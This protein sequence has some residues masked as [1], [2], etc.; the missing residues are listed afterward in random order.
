MTSLQRMYREHLYR[1]CTDVQRT[2]FIHYGED[3][4]TSLAFELSSE[5]KVRAIIPSK[6]FIVIPPLWNFFSPVLF[7]IIFLNII[8]SGNWKS[9][10]SYLYR[11]T[12]LLEGI[13][14]ILNVFWTDCIWSY[15]IQFWRD[16]RHL[17][18]YIWHSTTW[19]HWVHDCWR[20]SDYHKNGYVM[21]IVNESS[22]GICSSLIILVH[23]NN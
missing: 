16:Q 6:A 19:K 7:C 17:Q 8:V 21:L 11:N 14:M 4:C 23:S 22:T 1:G 15:G 2:F 3:E 20:S 9:T 5:T 13:I 10:S 12:W 18:T